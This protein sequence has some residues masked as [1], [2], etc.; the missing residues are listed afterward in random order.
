MITCPVVNDLRRGADLV[1]TMHVLALPETGSP[2]GVKHV[3]RRTLHCGGMV[4]KIH[5]P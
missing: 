5:G 3:S 4:G 1:P 2:E